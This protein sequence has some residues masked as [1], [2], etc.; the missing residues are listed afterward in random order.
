MSPEQARGEELDART[1]LFSLGVVLYEVATGHH[2]F[3]GNTTALIFDAIL[4]KTP[5]S[6]MRLN[7]R[8]PAE[9]ER[10]INK[11]LEKDADLRYQHASELRA[12]LKRLKRDTDSGKA[13]AIGK[14]TI[15]PAVPVKNHSRFWVAGAIVLLLILALATFWLRSPTPLPRVVDSTQITH[16]GFL[17]EC[18]VYQDLARHK[19]QC[20]GTRVVW[21][22]PTVLFR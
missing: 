8:L 7:P 5:I 1:D 3:P 21:L 16:D 17:Y 4:N 12:D 6:P 10:I 18:G 2:A 11:L 13:T 20:S 9:L 22:W 14:V 15:T 19:L